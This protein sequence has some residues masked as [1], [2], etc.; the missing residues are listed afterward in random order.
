MNEL[1]PPNGMQFGKSVRNSSDTAKTFFSLIP[2][3]IADSASGQPKNK[4]KSHYQ[5]RL[6]G[7]KK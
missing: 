5:K 2:S 3:T 1:L 4:N 7:D 6:N